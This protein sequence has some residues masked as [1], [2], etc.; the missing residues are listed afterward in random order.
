[1]SRTIFKISFFSFFL[2]IFIG[3]SPIQADDGWLDTVN[4]GGLNSI[5]TT[6]YGEDGEPKAIQE[7]I[8]MVIKT[9]LGLL[10][11]IFIILIIMAG[12][13]YMTAGGNEE[14]VKQAVSQIKNAIIGLLIVLASYSLTVFI[15]NTAL[16]ATSNSL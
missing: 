11:A 13:K 15:T 9:F 3:V 10:G 12:F 6:A 4:E 16:K 2:F 7:I 8:A 14:K 1:M 5:G